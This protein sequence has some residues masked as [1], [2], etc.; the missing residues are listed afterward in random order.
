MTVRRSTVGRRIDDRN[1]NVAAVRLHRITH[2]FG[3]FT[4]LDDVSLEVRQGEFVTLLGQSGSGKSTLLRI[5][6][7]LTTPSE[8][9]VF[10]AGEDVSA[11]PTQRR[12]IGFVFQN[13]ALFPHFTV[14]ENI[15]YPM[16][17]A[18]S[19]DRSSPAGPRRC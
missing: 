7:G 5:I 19:S 15:A 8:G 4:A 17:F 1:E 18:A 11:V 3:G 14:F 2:R 16:A 10:I 13:Y 12:G 6:A 9:Q